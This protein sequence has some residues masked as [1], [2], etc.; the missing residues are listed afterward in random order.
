MTLLV[1]AS[2]LSL[3]FPAFASTSATINQ[4]GAAVKT[5]EG[6]HN[7]TFDLPAGKIRVILPDDMAPGDTISG[8]VSTEPAGKNPEERSKNK[9][10]LNGTVLDVD[11]STRIPANQA[12]FTWK[13]L[14]KS[15]QRSGA[16]LMRMTA[17]YPESTKTVPVA[18]VPLA[19][20]PLTVPPSFTLPPIGQTGHPSQVTGPFDG[21]ASNT[22]C[23]VGGAPVDVIAESPR[24][25]VFQNPTDIVGPA[26]LSVREGNNTATGAYRTIGINLSAPKTDLKRGEQTTVSVRVSGLDGIT[27]D[28]PVHLVTTGTVNMQGGNTQD[29]R[30]SPNQVGPNGTFV[31]NFN[32][33]GTTAGTFSVVATVPGVNPPIAGNVA[34]ECICELNPN[35]IVTAGKKKVAGGAQHAFAPNVRLAACNGNQC[36]IAKTAYSWSVGAG[37]TATY[38]IV[39]NINDAKSISL[40]VTKKGTVELTVTV[41]ITCSDGKTC[42]DTDTKTF[43]VDV[44]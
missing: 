12:K 32:L 40:D 44:K 22:N 43:T 17:L 11:G 8:T 38:T 2:L 21:N 23:S 16:S 28:I 37:S 42:T 31:G 36:S 20:A 4:N 29:I 19:T 10:V 35:P 34:C 7:I 26:E 6:V 39:G 30:I 25:V 3:P 41:T 15:T 18:S 13:P 9:D 33:T 14:L 5:A 27:N 1:A 24:K